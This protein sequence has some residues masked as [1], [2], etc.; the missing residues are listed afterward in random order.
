MATAKSVEVTKLDTTP[1]TILE[2]GS[3]QGKMRVFQ[4][5]IAAGTGDIDTMMLLCLLKYLQTLK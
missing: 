2:A 4:D 3:G 1:R 5:T